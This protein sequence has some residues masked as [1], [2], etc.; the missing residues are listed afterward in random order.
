MPYFTN[1]GE[2]VEG[3]VSAARNSSSGNARSVF[4][5]D[6]S[7][8]AGM[9]FCV[10]PGRYGKNLVDDGVPANNSKENDE[11]SSARFESGPK[12]YCYDYLP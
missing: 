6:D 1:L 7:Y 10:N 11:A 9:A 12:I 2:V 8:L 4:Y 3:N 5:N